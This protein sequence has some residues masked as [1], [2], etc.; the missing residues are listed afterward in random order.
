MKAWLGLVAVLL[1][2]GATERLRLRLLLDI[3]VTI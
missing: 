2:I 1:V 3:S